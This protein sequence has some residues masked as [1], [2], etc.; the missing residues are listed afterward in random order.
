M[1]LYSDRG[2]KKKMIKVFLWAGTLFA[3][4][5]VASGAFASHALKDRFT[6]RTLAIFETATKY[7]MYHALA[8]ILL[9]T[10]WIQSSSTALGFQVAGWAFIAGIILFSGS[11]YALSLSGIKILGA[12]TP[13][14]G[15]A[16]L[17]GWGALA[18]AVA[19]FK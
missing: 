2:N 8:L 5:A 13:F 12:I 9:G 6:E 10:L 18:I 15:V 14:G 11:L 3:G 4:L 19:Q 16:F 1:L 17:I 7:Q